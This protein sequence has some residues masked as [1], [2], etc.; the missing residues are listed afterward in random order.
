MT[1]MPAPP[2]PPDHARRTTADIRAELCGP[3]GPFEVVEEQVGGAPMKVYKHRF[4]HLRAVAEQAARRG[5]QTFLVYGDRRVSFGEFFE[6]SA[7][8]AA[9]LERLGVAKGDRVAVLSANNPEWCETFWATVSLGA[10]LVGCNGWWKADEIHYGL[11]DS[12]AGVL[13]ADARRLERVADRLGDLDHLAHVVLIDAAPSDV[14]PPGLLAPEGPLQAWRFDEVAA[15]ATSLPETDIAEDDPALIFYTSGTTGRPKGAVST[16]R[17]MVANLQNTLY[18]TVAA[19]RR[20]EPADATATARQ[21]EPADETVADR[22]R[23]ATVTEP[24]EPTTPRAPT[25]SLMTSPLFHVAGLHSSLVVGTLAGV[26]LVMT[27]G[28]FEPRQALELIEREKVTIWATVPTMVWRVCEWEGR[29]DFD[30]TSV[31]TVAFGGSPAAPE[32]RRLIAETFPN[33]TSTSNVYGLTESNSAATIINGRDLEERPGSVGP[34][35]PVVD[36]RIVDAGG[37]PV[38]TGTDG[39]ICLRG[40]IIT[41]GYWGKPEET[42]AAIVDGWLHTGDIGHLDDDGYLYLTDRAKDVIIRGGE[43]VYSVEIEHRLVEHPEVLDAGVVGVPHPALG[44]EVEAVV[45]VAAG[46][47]LSVDG[48]RAWVAETL[49]DFKVPERIRFTHE[50]LPRNPSGKLLKNVLR[51]ESDNQFTESL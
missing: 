13:V 10:V 33:V 2:P 41:P 39:E 6:R 29:H 49:A 8:L 7:A 40:P 36:V 27:V 24:V 48:A 37:E 12:G 42:A 50:R 30:T 21:N 26:R 28:R 11:A 32:L 9:G 47:T 17:N 15:E 1:A 44:E 23:D 22:R 43:N 18:N 46:S 35:V 16:H 19:R 3:G 20:D 38:P 4:P 14:L 31:T 45:Q 5:D 25:V 51:G 34:P